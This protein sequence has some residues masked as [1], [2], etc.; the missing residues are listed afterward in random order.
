MTTK[1]TIVLERRIG[2]VDVDVDIGVFAPGPNLDEK[3]FLTHKGNIIL[4]HI[5]GSVK[6]GVNWKDQKLQYSGIT[7]FSII[8]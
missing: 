2:D 5:I 1:V 4:N 6:H 3:P 8:N 7:S